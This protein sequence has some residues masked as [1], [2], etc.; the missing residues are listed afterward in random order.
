MALAIETSPVSSGWRNEFEHLALEFGEL[1]EEK[2]AAMRERDFA[3][4]R[5]Q[6][7]ADQSRHRG[8]M[9]RATERPPIGER[10]AFDLA[11]DR[12]DHRDFQQLLRRERRQDRRQPRRK[13]RLAGAGRPD[14]QEVMSA[15][16]GDFERALAA[17][18]SLDV[19][20]IE[21]SCFHLADAGLRPRQHLR[22]AK[23]VRKLDQ[24]RRGD[25][26]HLGTSPC[27]FRPA[28]L[29]ADQALASG[30]R[31]DRR[32]QHAGNGCNRAVE[33]EFAQHGEA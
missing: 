11:R 29:R 14:H 7:A 15:G 13:H 4:P 22:A 28:G 21:R 8:G 1:V 16:G 31:A 30:I 5:A 26:F 25:D 23:M 10:A 19:G 9:M 2:N 24:R 3:R 33:P 18:L 32:G 6:A 27:G 12:S 20:K 17:L